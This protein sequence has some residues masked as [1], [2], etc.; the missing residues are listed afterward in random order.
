MRK[1]FLIVLVVAA[2]MGLM[3]L[4]S[5]AKDTANTSIVGTWNYSVLGTTYQTFVFKS[6]STFTETVL[7]TSVSG[8]YTAASGTLTLNFSAS[9]SSTYT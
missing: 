2:A 6:D 1:T 5:C 4:S 9:T 8:T 7:G 3:T